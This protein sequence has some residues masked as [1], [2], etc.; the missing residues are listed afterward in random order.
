MFKG[1]QMLL[2]R[3]IRKIRIAKG[4]TQADLADKIN[5]S[6]SAYGQI[7]R[8]AGKCTFETLYKIAKALIV[9]ISYLVNIDESN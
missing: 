3:R 2:A 1:L 8:R 9:S 6:P 7:E 5:I 4:L